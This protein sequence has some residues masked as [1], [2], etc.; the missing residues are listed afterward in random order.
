MSFR[1][2]STKV[3]VSAAPPSSTGNCSESPS[4][5]S[6][7]RLSFITSVDFTSSPD[8]PMASALCATAASMM[9]P[10]GCLMPRFT[11]VY[12][13]LVKMMSTRFL[14]MSWTSP[15]TVASTIVP[16]PTSPSAFSMCG[17][18]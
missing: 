1:S 10:T 18:R 13:L 9:L 16:L 5:F 4:R 3:R 15:F 12:P 6:S 7:N 17:S 11:T 2:C 8:M 14:P